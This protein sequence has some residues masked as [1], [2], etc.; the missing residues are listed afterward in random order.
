M[1]L[2]SSANVLRL[3][4]TLPKRRRLGVVSKVYRLYR[5]LGLKLPS[6]GFAASRLTRFNH[7]GVRYEVRV[8]SS[9]KGCMYL[10]D[11]ALLICSV[12]FSISLRGP[13]PY[14]P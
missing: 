6:F 14:L 4:G 7:R 9:S 3:R 8:V 5:L 13:K 2:A 1:E 10:S 11:R 12:V